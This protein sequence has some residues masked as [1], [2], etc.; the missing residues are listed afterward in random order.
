VI[1]GVTGSVIA[2]RSIDAQPASRSTR[3][4]WQ[5]WLRNGSDEPLPLQSA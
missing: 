3:A 5:G 2:L 1:N 4:M